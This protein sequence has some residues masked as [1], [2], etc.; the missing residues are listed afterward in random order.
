ME[1][2]AAKMQ[3]ARIVRRESTATT[4]QVWDVIADGWTY[5]AWVV[6]ASRVRSVDPGWPSP[7]TSLRHS[8]GTW[9]AVLDD[10]TSV[11]E[12]DPG[13]RILLRARTRPVGVHTVEITVE[14]SGSGSVVQMR[15][16]GTSGP[17]RLLPRAARQAALVLRNRETLHRLCLL[18]ERSTDPQED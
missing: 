14:A 3:A 16:D 4:Q 15:E 7:G 8:I 13:R 10:S 5:G 11:I 9:P 17:V 18:A 12:A 2:P 1:Q 6:G